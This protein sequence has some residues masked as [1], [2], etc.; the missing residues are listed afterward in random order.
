M[1]CIAV[2][3]KS[4]WTRLRHEGGRRNISPR[5][6]DGGVGESLVARGHPHWFRNERRKGARGFVDCAAALRCSSERLRR[7]GFSAGRSYNCGFGESGGE[8]AARRL[9]TVPP[10]F[11][12]G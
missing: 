5:C 12:H 4:G 1:S 3:L 2:P 9:L 11:D 6:C 7:G 10:D 8:S